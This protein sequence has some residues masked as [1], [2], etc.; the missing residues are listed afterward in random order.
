LT[1]LDREGHPREHQRALG[2]WLGEPLGIEEDRA[3]M[4]LGMAAD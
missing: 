4:G 3:S 1:S 2:S